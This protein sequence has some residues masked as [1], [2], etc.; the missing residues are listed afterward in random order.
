[1]DVPTASQLLDFLGVH[2]WGRKVSADEYQHRCPLHDDQK[3]SASLN[4]RNGLWNCLSGDTRVVTDEGIF[5]IKELSGSPHKLLDAD[6]KWVNSPVVCFGKQR[7]FKITLTRNKQT[8]VIYATGNHRWPLRTGAKR[9]R[10][11]ATT[12]EL[13][14]GHRLRSVTPRKRYDETIVPDYVC[15]GFVYGDGTKGQAYFCGEK[16]R[17]MLKWFEGVG[18]APL[19]Y[20]NKIVITGIPQEWKFLPGINEGR[21]FLFS[22]LAGYFAADGCVDKNGQVI[23]AS[24]K[25]EDLEFVRLACNELGIGTYGIT[26]Q[27]RKGFSS[28]PSELF[29]LRFLGST[30]PDQFFLLP[31]HKERFLNKNYSYERFGW[32]VKSVEQTDRKEDV[33]CA[34]VPSTHSFVLEDNILTGNC[35]VCGGRSIPGLIREVHDIP[36]LEAVDIFVGEFGGDV[37]TWDEI[38]ALVKAKEEEPKV[39]YLS[40]AQLLALPTDHTLISRGIRPETLEKYE[41]KYHEGKDAVLYPVYSPDMVYIGHSAK[42]VS[43]G[44]KGNPAGF[45]KSASFFGLPQSG[46]L[47]GEYRSTRLAVLV[48]GPVDAMKVTQAGYDGVVACIGSHISPRQADFLKRTPGVVVFLDRDVAGADGTW[49]VW[50]LLRDSVPLHAVRYPDTLIGK[51]PGDLDGSL[52]YKML[53]RIVP[54]DYRLLRS[55]FDKEKLKDKLKKKISD[56]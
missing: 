26:S 7:L 55:E 28:T 37:R 15:A 42:K 4:M 2:T 34:V 23:L 3:A 53:C 32:V 49:R 9:T 46:L 39:G 52:I 51:D 25:R 5:P 27:W 19:N 38:R 24:S 31:R 22:W 40:R 16:D 12:I 6:G 44:E 35:F 14:S 56:W 30:L 36:F 8:K 47:N 20:G 1:M 48:E 10:S 29:F 45:D 33:Y 18:N 11:E 43:T 50:K 41:V 54:L 17:H 13:L 21:D